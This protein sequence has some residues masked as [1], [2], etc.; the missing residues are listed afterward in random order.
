MSDKP[1][2]TAIERLEQLLD[3]KDSEIKRLQNKL[4]AVERELDREAGWCRHV[5]YEGLSKAPNP[6]LPVPRLEIR[7][8]APEN[9][10]HESEAIYSLV[11]RH[12]VDHIVFVPLGKTTSS[13][14]LVDRVRGDIVETPFRE[15]CHFANE[16]WQLKLPGFVI[17]G[18]RVY[19][20]KLCSRCGRLEETHRRVPFGDKC[21]LAPLPGPVAPV[22]PVESTP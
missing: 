10:R 7:W 11:Y 18:D 16:M 4:D 1:R 12:L 22:V 9:G 14:A 5:V 19:E 13:G 15:G 21:T 6:E 2:T 17:A 20:A 8:R 3:D